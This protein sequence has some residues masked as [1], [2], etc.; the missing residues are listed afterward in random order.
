MARPEF[1]MGAR[2]LPREISS[3][4]RFPIRRRDTRA[5]NRMDQARR[6]RDATLKPRILYTCTCKPLYDRALCTR[7]RRVKVSSERACESEGHLLVP[8]L[9]PS[10]R[11]LPVANQKWDSYRRDKV[12]WSLL[13]SLSSIFLPMQKYIFETRVIL[14]KKR[15]RDR[16]T[17]NFPFRNREKSIPIMASDL[18]RIK[19]ILSRGFA[20]SRQCDVKRKLVWVDALITL[21]FNGSIMRDRHSFRTGQRLRFHAIALRRVLH[22]CARRVP[23]SDK[24]PMKFSR[25]LIKSREW[26]QA[27]VIGEVSGDNKFIRKISLPAIRGRTELGKYR[28]FIYRNSLRSCDRVWVDTLIHHG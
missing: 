26:T 15:F 18:S 25:I 22:F 10:L 19:Q 20:N 3:Q 12:T 13:P 24:F 23:V 5:T 28:Q 4:G 17:F 1:I 11:R 27:A 21:S 8:K 2:R 9:I 6:R 14:R 16:E 7:W